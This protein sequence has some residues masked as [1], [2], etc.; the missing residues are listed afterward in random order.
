MRRISAGGGRKLS[1]DGCA[2]GSNR[3]YGFAMGYKRSATGLG[4]RRK[5][6]SSSMKSSS[7][8]VSRKVSTSQAP[9]S[10]SLSLKALLLVALTYSI[11]W[12]DIF[13]NDTFSYD[14]TK[15]FPETETLRMFRDSPNAHL[16]SLFSFTHKTSSSNEPQ[17]RFPFE[18]T[19]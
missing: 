18:F 10:S 19:R 11:R 13:P 8:V 3:G 14:S 2:Q 16:D 6:S 9:F 5:V 12:S 15:T 17:T 4:R 1:S 7:V